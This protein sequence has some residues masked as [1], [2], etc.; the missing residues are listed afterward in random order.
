MRLKESQEI[1][2]SQAKTLEQF[3]IQISQHLQEIAE[4]ESHNERLTIEIQNLGAI[5]RQKEADVKGMSDQHHRELAAFA[6]EREVIKAP[7]L[8]QI[9]DLE[10]RANQ[11][12]EEK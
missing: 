11:W 9:R 8:N 6:L 4:L 3:Q 12:I 2:T 1:R 10:R 5:L 7:L